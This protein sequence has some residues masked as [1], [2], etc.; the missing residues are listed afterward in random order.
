MIIFIPVAA[1]SVAAASVQNKAIVILRGAH[2]H[3]AHPHTKP[4]SKDRRILEKAVE[5]AGVVGLTVGKLLNAPSTSLVYNG[6]RLAATSP[7]FMDSRKLRD[8]IVERRLKDHPHGMGWEGVLHHVS[9]KEASLL[10]TERY[11][12]TAMSKNG[13]RLVVTLHPQIAMFIHQILS[14]NIDYTFKRVDGK[15][16]EW[17]VAGMADRFKQR[18]TFASLFCD[19]KTQEAFSQLFTELFDTVAEVTGKQLKLAPFFPDANCRIVMLDGEVP[20]ALGLGHFLATY[21]DPQISGINSRNAVAL[22]SHCLKTCC[23]HFE[24]HIDELSREIPRLVI[25]RLKTI[26]GLSTQQEIDDWHTFCAAQPYPDVKNWYAHK[27]ANPWILPSINKFLSNIPNDNWV[28]TP[29][30]SNIV[31]TAHA[32]RNAETAIGVGLLTAILQCVVLTS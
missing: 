24:R 4:S 27:L 6:D 8:A 21:N 18:I 11:I 14:L 10:K 23:L 19:T 15:M 7:A 17:E 22:L 9:T 29:N 1:S 5:A 12:H 26:M 30:H 2:N 3:P 31:E 32:G 25:S 13:F 28:I 16:D 20:Q